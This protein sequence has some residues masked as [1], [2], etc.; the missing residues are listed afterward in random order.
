MILSWN[1]Y[2]NYLVCQNMTPDLMYVLKRDTWSN[3]MS[4][5]DT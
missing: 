3:Y 2:P 5:H 1:P 4:E